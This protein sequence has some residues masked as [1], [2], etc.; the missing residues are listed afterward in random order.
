MFFVKFD[1]N[2]VYFLYC[3]LFEMKKIEDHEKI[4]KVMFLS[5]LTLTSSIFYNVFYMIVKTKNLF[6]KLSSLKNRC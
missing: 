6:L 5:N 1:F 2:F 4:D 3:I